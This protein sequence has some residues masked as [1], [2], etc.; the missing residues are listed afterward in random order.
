MAGPGHWDARYAS[1]D[2]ASLS[3]FQPVPTVSLELLDELGVTPED[4]V[5]DIGGG[6][7]RLVDHLVARGHGDLAVLDVSAVALDAA[8]RRLGDP[9]GVEW[10]RADLLSWEP[11]RR[12]A[13]WHDRAVLHFLVDDA[14]RAAYA[15]LVR[16]SLVPGGA[17]VIGV[18]AE[19]GPTECSGL[20]VRGSTVEELAAL[21]GDVEV[22]A[23]RRALHRT[24]AGVEQPF[25][26]L[27]A[28]VS[29]T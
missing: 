15:R 25:A 22:V 11:H 24:R 20:P 12:W 4:S 9:L 29:T 23:G 17:V 16:R 5:I 21:I 6:S 7:S 18:F 10:M 2:E 19:D 8:R 28:R 13:V 14:D 1:G 26:W 3:W 27:A